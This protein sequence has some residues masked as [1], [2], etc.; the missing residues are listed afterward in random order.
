MPLH[1]NRCFFE[2]RDPLELGVTP[3]T[4]F[5]VLI[6]PIQRNPKIKIG[7]WLKFYSNSNKIDFKDLGLPP[8]GPLSI[9]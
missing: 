6:S 7:L 1:L 8:K 4:K 9:Q 5:W 2:L 3:Q